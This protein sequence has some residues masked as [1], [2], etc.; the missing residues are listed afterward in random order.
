MN[1]LR[2]QYETAS[3]EALLGV[4]TRSSQVGV[5]DAPTDGS[6]LRRLNPPNDLSPAMTLSGMGR[7]IDSDRS[8]AFSL[9][10]SH[11]SSY[12]RGRSI[13]AFSSVR[14]AGRLRIANGHAGNRASDIHKGSLGCRG[15][16]LSTFSARASSPRDEPSTTGSSVLGPRTRP[17]SIHKVL[18]FCQ[19]GHCYPPRL[20]RTNRDSPIGVPWQQ[21]GSPMGSWTKAT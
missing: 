6:E 21:T 4:H 19:A 5:S 12:T 16:N 3:L 14:R 15:T 9:L 20:D 11:P 17:V 18:R 10:V 13:G 7:F 2:F 1:C 8:P